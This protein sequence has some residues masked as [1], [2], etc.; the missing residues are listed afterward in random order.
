MKQD[1]KWYDKLIYEIINTNGWDIWP[2][3]LK[4]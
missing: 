1:M 4:F 3:V 2:L